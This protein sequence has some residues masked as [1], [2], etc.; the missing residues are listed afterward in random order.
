MSV[1]KKI[2]AN[3]ISITPFNVHKEYNVTMHNYSGSNCGLGVQILSANFRSASFGDPIRGRDINSEPRNPNNTYKSIIYDSINHLYYQR[4]DKPSENFGGNNPE[5]ETRFLSEKAHV[6]SVPSTVFD[7]KIKSG[8]INF[9]DKY[10]DSLEISYERGID[11]ESNNTIYKYPVLLANRFAFE[12]SQSM[13]A[14]SE[15]ANFSGVPDT[16]LE[17]ARA[18]DAPQVMVVT[19]SGA[20]YVGTGSMLFKVSSVDSI[21]LGS[22]EVVHHNVGNGLLLKA[23]SQFKGIT[24]QNWWTNI[25]ASKEKHGMPVYN[26]TMW[27]KPPDPSLMPNGVTGAPGQSHLLTR[28]KNAYFELNILTSSLKSN[29]YNPKGLLPLQMFFGATKDNCTTSESRDVLNSGFGLATGSWNLVNIQQEFWPGDNA[30][31]GTSGSFTDELPPW[32]HSP[33]KTTLRIYR[34]DPVSNNGFTY[35]KK[36]GYATASL[37]QPRWDNQLYRSVTSSIQYSRNLYIGASGSRPQGAADNNST[38]TTLRGAFTG[39]IDDIRFYESIL[40]DTH[41]ENLAFNPKMDLRRTPPITASFNLKDD[42]FGNLI[43]T[44]IP[45]K[46][47][48]SSDN[49]VGYYGFNELFTVKNQTSASH[50]VHMHDGLGKT[51]ILD[52]SKNK[53]HGVSD[54]V[55]YIPG[56]V[57]QNQ[58]GSVRSADSINYYQTNVA[59]GIRANF[60][61][62][63]SIKIPHIHDLNLD[64]DDGFSISF[65]IKI[66]ENQV[67]GVN[68][69]IGSMPYTTT[70]N[71][72]LPGNA[73]GT[74]APCVN[75]LSGSSAGRDYVTLITKSGLSR[76]VVKNAAT[77][78][79]IIRPIQ[80]LAAENTYPYH[81]E[82]KNTSYERHNQPFTPGLGC[83]LGAPLNTIVVRRKGKTSKI[84]LESNNALTP[85]IENHVVIRKHSNV[86]QIWINGKLD[87]YGVDGVDCTD[88]ISDLFIGDSGRSWI[89]GS[90]TVKSIEDSF[91]PPHNPFSGSID[92]VRFYNTAITE[93]NIL[94]LYDNNL[95]TPTAYQTNNVGNVFYEHGMV[96]ITNTHIPKFFSG[97]LHDGQAYI[98]NS[99][100]MW[101]SNGKAIFSKDFSLKLKN[102]RTIYEQSIKCHAKA[103][104][105]NLSTNPTLRKKTVGS[106]E[107]ILSVQELADFAK[108]PEFNPYITTVGL[109]DEFGRLLAI[110]K[111]AKPIPKL[112]NVDMTFVVRFDK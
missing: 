110:A 73:G 41:L 28:D 91:I 50:D 4:V 52:F 88:N 1:F 51:T 104:D 67:P 80:G 107:E 65:W 43:D 79:K 102:T 42:G 31:K 71:Q 26:V 10:I 54:K 56:I 29:T 38:S 111:L 15:V 13:Y 58:S 86:L 83:Q 17:D 49:L 76:E 99:G 36:V 33:A 93:E 69:I 19:G 40:T 30:F 12:S 47:I 64:N 100:S 98:G 2:D 18:V 37:A 46:S 16:S 3:D 87:K 72:T 14:D 97:S 34:P 48:I 60:N 45:T 25:A 74:S 53:N 95:N 59:S 75:I 9:T 78:E 112:K 7:L 35:I 84:V 77:G 103:S 68:T 32:G 24:K 8:S 106:C 92:E 20:G 27:V 89:T 11:S 94:G 5:L 82:L 66:P 63:G 108:E 109:Y 55:K 44:A 21:T 39:S 81:I 62:S 101:D 61:N 90:A 22:G 85:L 6:I 23:A 96:T 105:F 70:G 57:V